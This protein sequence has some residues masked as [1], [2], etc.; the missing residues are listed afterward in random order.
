MAGKSCRHQLIL[1]LHGRCIIGLRLTAQTILALVRT[2]NITSKRV[3]DL[4]I[5]HR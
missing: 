3:A 5:S 4:M 1:V 2:L